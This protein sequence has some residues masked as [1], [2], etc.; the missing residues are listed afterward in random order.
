MKRDRMHQAGTGRRN[1][2]GEKKKRVH[3]RG[4]S[5]NTEPDMLVEA[6]LAQGKVGLLSA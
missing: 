6:H 4:R 3:I 1:M 5:C 2:R